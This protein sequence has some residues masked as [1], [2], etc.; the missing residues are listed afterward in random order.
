LPWSGGGEPIWYEGDERVNNCSV[1]VGF[2]DQEMMAYV[3]GLLRDFEENYR[4]LPEDKREAVTNDWGQSMTQDEPARET[5]ELNRSQVSC[6]A[7]GNTTSVSVVLRGNSAYVQTASIALE[8]VDRI[9][10]N[11]HRTAG[12]ASAP[13][14][15]GARELLGALREEGYVAW[16]TRAF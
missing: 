5:P 7:R 4:D 6:Q 2:K 9:L 16:E 11:R 10:N 15:V 3:L 13:A 12:F 1:M 8:T 14:V